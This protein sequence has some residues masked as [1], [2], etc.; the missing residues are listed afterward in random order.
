M[1]FPQKVAV[2][3]YSGK[4]DAGIQAGCLFYGKNGVSPGVEKT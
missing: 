4:E 2:K 1:T 3:T